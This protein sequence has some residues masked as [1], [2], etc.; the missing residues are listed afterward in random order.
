MSVIGQ[1]V[2]LRGF[3]FEDSL[4]TYNLATGITRADV[5]KAMTLDTTAANKMKLAGDGDP[6]F[7]RLETVEDRSVEGVLVGTVALRFSGVLP[8]DNADFAGISI[9]DEVQGSGDGAVKSLAAYVDT[10]GT[11]DPEVTA[12]T[13]QKS[14]F[15]VEK[16]DGDTKFV[17]VQKV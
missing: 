12:N 8:V 15:V 9:G 1:G 14:N 4:F 3:H 7:G 11:G 13:H 10:D 2:T 5:G 6:I 17:V 16:I